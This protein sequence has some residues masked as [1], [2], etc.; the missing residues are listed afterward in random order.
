[1]EGSGEMCRGDLYT[2][3][4]EG[5]APAAPLGKPGL[6]QRFRQ[7]QHWRQSSPGG[8][9]CSPL[10]ASEPL[11]VLRGDLDAFLA[12]DGLSPAGLLEI[13]RGSGSDGKQWRARGSVAAA[14]HRWTARRGGAAGGWRA[15]PRAAAE[16]EEPEGCDYCQLAGEPPPAGGS[17]AKGRARS[18][19]ADAGRWCWDGGLSDVEEAEDSPSQRFGLLP[20]EGTLWMASGGFGLPGFGEAWVLS[21]TGP[22]RFGKAPVW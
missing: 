21:A 14:W 12:E 16:G 9:L 3:L 11:A 22:D 18:V 10:V 20:D 4:D 8:S 2:F 1:M 5:P 17:G 6:L 13:S 7:A 15:A 19:P